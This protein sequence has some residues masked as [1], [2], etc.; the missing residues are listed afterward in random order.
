V[1]FRIMRSTVLVLR[2]LQ[3]NRLLDSSFFDQASV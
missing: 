2:I 1:I 3:G